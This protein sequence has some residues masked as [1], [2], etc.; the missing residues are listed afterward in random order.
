[1][2]TS[3]QENIDTPPRVL[4]ERERSLARVLRD[5][6]VLLSRLKREQEAD[7]LYTEAKKILSLSMQTWQI[8]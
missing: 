5:H 6:A 2:E 8:N 4:R 7:R 3:L 1:V